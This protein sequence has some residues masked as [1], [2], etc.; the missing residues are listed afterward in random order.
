MLKAIAG[1]IAMAAGLLMAG[2]PAHGQAQRA[3]ES[4]VWVIPLNN[5]IGYSTND[6]AGTYIS[7]T[8]IGARNANVIVRPYNPSVDARGRDAEVRIAVARGAQ[9]L[10]SFRT[11]E[12]AFV[13]VLASEP[14]LVG[15][16]SWRTSIGQGSRSLSSTSGGRIIGLPGA[17]VNARVEP[18]DQWTMMPTPAYAVDCAGAEPGH[19]ACGLLVAF[20]F[21]GVTEQLP[22]RAPTETEQASPPPRAP[23]P[24]YTP[25]PR[26]SPTPQRTSRPL[27][28]REL[29]R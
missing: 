29:P 6:Y 15:A 28:R 24:R 7:V 4:K 14:V 18:F 23:E 17:E 12:P 1:A 19:F 13:I 2:G 3:V 27:P 25:S 11:F 26:P 10:A 9:G 8:N 20:R 16:W 22:D 21:P 5:D